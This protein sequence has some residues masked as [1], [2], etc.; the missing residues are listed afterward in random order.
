MLKQTAVHGC[1]VT[2]AKL[3]SWCLDSRNQRFNLL[4][5]SIMEVTPWSSSL[6]SSAAASSWSS[7]AATSSSSSTKTLS[8]NHPLQDYRSVLNTDISSTPINLR[9]VL[10]SFCKSSMNPRLGGE[11]PNA[12]LPG[13]DCWHWWLATRGNLWRETLPSWWLRFFTNPFLKKY[14]NRQ[15]GADRIS[16]EIRVKIPKNIGVAAHLVDYIRN[17]PTIISEINDSCR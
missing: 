5:L 3:L 10:K 17:N 15:I 4:P 7:A 12:H 2:F 16:P 6:S 11:T 13:D 9:L 14:A 1:F 8:I